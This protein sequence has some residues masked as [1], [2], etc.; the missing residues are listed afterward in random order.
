M[1]IIVLK[2]D[3]VRMY[4]KELRDSILRTVKSRMHR[5]Y[6]LNLQLACRQ[7]IPHDMLSVETYEMRKHLLSL[8]L[9]K[10]R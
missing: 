3:Q 8:P 6:P 5:A 9:A 4:N 1:T 2:R 7:Q 10:L